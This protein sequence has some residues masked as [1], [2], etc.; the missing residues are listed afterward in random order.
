MRKAESLW[1]SLFI[2]KGILVQVR[3]SVPK[4]D[5]PLCLFGIVTHCPILD[6]S[7]LTCPEKMLIFDFREAV[8]TKWGVPMGPQDQLGRSI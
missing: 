7:L 3:E 6:L 4:L 1:V 2:I 8:R 5:S